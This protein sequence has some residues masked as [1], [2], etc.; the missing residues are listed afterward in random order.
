MVTEREVGTVKFFN[1][2]GW[3]YIARSGQADIYVHYTGINRGV[4][5]HGYR[6]LEAGQNVNFLVGS[7]GGKPIALDVMILDIA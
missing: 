7:Q 3:G 6:E 5:E 2:R 4:N 1:E